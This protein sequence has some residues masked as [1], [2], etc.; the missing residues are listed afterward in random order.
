MQIDEPRKTQIMP[1]N[2]SAKVKEV[3]INEVFEDI[4]FSEE[5]VIEDAYQHGYQIGTSEDSIEGYHLGYHRGA[6]FG[7]ELG[8]YEALAQYYIE[9]AENLRIPSKILKP[10]NALKEGCDE[11][12]HTNSE[13]TDLFEA[14]EKLRVLYKKIAAQLKI[15]S[16]FKKEGIQF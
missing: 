4:L 14:I 3:D 7:S 1:N 2:L 13:E 16:D 12:P 6:E 9:N 15:K 11:F 8:Y 5:K 10:L